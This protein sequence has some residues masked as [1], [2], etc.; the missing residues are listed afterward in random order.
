MNSVN[1]YYSPKPCCQTIY[2]QFYSTV[3]YHVDVKTVICVG[4]II[5]TTAGLTGG[6]VAMLAD[7]G[8]ALTALTDA[9]DSL[10]VLRDRVLGTGTGEA[11]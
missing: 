2:D 1:V 8:D 11:V 4:I 10:P 6:E 7:S 3:H 9:G 5:F